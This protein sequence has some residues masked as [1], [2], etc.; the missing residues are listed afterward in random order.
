MFSHL[1]NDQQRFRQVE[2]AS[3]EEIV[4]DNQGEGEENSDVSSGGYSDMDDDEDE[5]NTAMSLSTK[6]AE[7]QV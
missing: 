6:Q 5:G 7:Q 3:S 1:L 2:F 4:S